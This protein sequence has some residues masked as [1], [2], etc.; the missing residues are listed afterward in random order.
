[1]MLYLTI[2]V[3]FFNEIDEVASTLYTRSFI[4][5][6]IKSYCEHE[7]GHPVHSTSSER[8]LTLSHLA[9]SSPDGR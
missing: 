7:H 4:D 3:N 2:K 9:W 6:A 5:A 8:T 1:M